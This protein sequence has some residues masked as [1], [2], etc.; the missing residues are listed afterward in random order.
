MAVPADKAAHFILI[1]SQVFAP[2]K[3]LFNA[4]AASQ[5][6]DL[7]KQ[8]G[9]GRSKDQIIRQFRGGIAGAADQQGMPSIILS[10]VPHRHTRPVKPP[11]SFGSL[12]QPQAFPG[13]LRDPPLPPLPP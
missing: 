4:P 11:R 2:L 10:A 9:G 8:R 6:R 12:P 1:Q 13:G 3:I 5:S 7:G